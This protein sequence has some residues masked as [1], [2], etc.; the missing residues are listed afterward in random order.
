[1]RTFVEWRTTYG[2][3]DPC[4]DELRAAVLAECE[5]PATTP[6]QQSRLRALAEL[7]RAEQRRCEEHAA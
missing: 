6:E 2:I 3:A 1:M 4:M 7:I 5:K